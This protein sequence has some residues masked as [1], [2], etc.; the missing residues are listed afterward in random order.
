LSSGRPSLILAAVALL[1]LAPSLVLGTLISH[2]SA[3]NL[4][5]ATQFAEQFRAGIPYPRW[6]PQSFEGL[7]SPA[8]YFYPPLPFWIDAV[9]SLLT[10][11]LM[12]VPYR[13]AVTSAVI[14]FASGLAMQAWLR[15]ET[16]KP[17]VALW[18]AVAYMAAPY[19]LLDHYMRG[20]LAEFTAFVFVPLVL[21]GVRRP[22]LLPLAYAGLVLSHLPTALLVTATVLPAYVLARA[23]TLGELARI[24]GGGVLGL[25]L[26]AVYLVPA[27]SLQGWISADQLWAS[28]YRVER[29]FV[30]TP[31]R[32]P[33]PYIM[34]VVTWFT[35]GYALAAAGALLISRRLFW[36]LVSLACLGLVAGLVPW[37][38][39]LPELAKVQFPW[40]LLVVVDFAT[41]TSLCAAPAAGPQR[42]RFYVVAAALIA[43][44]PGMVLTAQDTVTGVGVLLK[45]GTLRQQDVKEYEPRGFPQAPNLGFAELG[46]EPVRDL[47]QISCRPA[48]D[49]CTASQLP[50]GGLAIDI[51]AEQ[52][53]D[54]VVR[55]F[56]FPAWQ[57]EPAR[58]LVP[59][60][61]LKLVR[62]EAGPGRHTYRLDRGVLPEER[63][64][65][66]IS[67]AALVLLLAAAL[68]A[69]RSAGYGR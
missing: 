4:T 50:F 36:P 38:W 2:S 13:L 65:W 28:F 3:Q 15:A 63:L 51:Q 23:R 21:L 10:V 11:N 57:L 44:L 31:S 68:L 19:H 26:A 18:G 42:S 7:G 17:R 30:L 37:F 59:T 52:A 60:P 8:F 46:L 5:W 24:I 1:V 9:V 27:M 55:R 29:W 35:I 64:G 47:P 45:R 12:P 40:R 20:A 39:D 32:W 53:T 61:D 16:Q 66:A 43:F 34:A 33:E 48:A 67:G 6:M 69:R 58:P 14:L 56:F 25:G 41:V 54:V 22:A 62:F 49:V